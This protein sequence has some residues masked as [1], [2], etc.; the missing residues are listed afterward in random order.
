MHFRI[1]NTSSFKQKPPTGRRKMKLHYDQPGATGG[2][3][4]DTNK[5]LPVELP[6]TWSQHVIPL[7]LDKFS[8]GLNTS[9]I[10]ATVN[11]M[12]S[13]AEQGSPV[14]AVSNAI[15]CAYRASVTGSANARSNMVHAYGNALRTVKTALDDPVEYK[16]DSTL[17]AVWMFVVYEVFHVFLSS[18]IF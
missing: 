8:I 10:F 18:F 17:L 6:Q 4:R 12:V 15:A 2:M 13:M 11:G 16:E 3:T 9:S 14:Y 7:I 1:V 5:C